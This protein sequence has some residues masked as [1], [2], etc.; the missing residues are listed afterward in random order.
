[1][2]YG[3][4][5]AVRRTNSEASSPSDR[6]CLDFGCWSQHVSCTKHLLRINVS[7]GTFCAGNSSLR[8]D[9]VL[10]TLVYPHPGLLTASGLYPKTLLVSSRLGGGA[11][12][13][14]LMTHH[15]EDERER[16]SN[17]HVRL[18]AFRPVTPSQSMLYI[19]KESTKGSAQREPVRRWARSLPSAV[20]RR[21][22]A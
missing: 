14:L 21:Q 6:S 1:M 2:H 8:R 13:G 7:R 16:P 10:E 12:T 5:V 4:G 17:Q 22:S 15:Q 18:R 19:R 9:Y 20:T 11:A 3:G